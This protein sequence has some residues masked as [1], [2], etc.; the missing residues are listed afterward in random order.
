MAQ[1]NHDEVDLIYVIKKL[2]EVIKHWIVLLFRAVDF[3]KKYWWIIAALI[4]L[5]LGLG[6]YAQ[7]N[8]DQGKQARMIVKINFDNTSYIY[9]SIDIINAKIKHLDADFF[10]LNNIDKHADLKD[11]S[12]KPIERL[13]DVVSGYEINN[14]NIEFVFKNLEFEEETTVN[15]FVS[16]DFK[17]HELTIKTTSKGDEKQV[18]QII[19]YFNK[20]ELIQE[21]RDQSIASLEEKLLYNKKT[22]DQID[23]VIES[24]LIKDAAILKESQVYI[25]QGLNF[26]PILLAKSDIQKENDQLTKALVVSKEAVIVLGDIAIVN[27]DKRLLDKKMIVYPLLFT[28]G[29]LLLG[30]V[31]YIF[32]YLRTIAS[33]NE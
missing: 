7:K 17:F 24:Y 33:D 8:A 20:N 4:I 21:I 15:N 25:D 26:H 10:N 5:G 13:R 1:N 32:I 2:K 29:F 22:L 31:R 28:V 6:Y 30:W 18:K 23:K 3:A 11:I 19:D 14:R 27:V 16:A 12:I 9:N